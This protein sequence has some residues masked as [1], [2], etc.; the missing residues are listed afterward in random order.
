[1]AKRTFQS[2]LRKRKNPFAK[3]SWSSPTFS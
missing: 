3:I 1:M 2:S